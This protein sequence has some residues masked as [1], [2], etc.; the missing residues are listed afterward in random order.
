MTL[1]A[2]PYFELAPRNRRPIAGLGKDPAQTAALGGTAV[3]GILV[4]AG[5][6]ALI[7]FMVAASGDRYTVR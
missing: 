5:I 1:G 3:M 6:G 2:H 4:V 7:Y